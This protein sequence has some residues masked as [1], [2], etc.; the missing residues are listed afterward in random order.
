[1]P[2]VARPDLNHNIIWQSDR[3]ISAAITLRLYCRSGG[4]AWQHD[5]N[6]SQIA[7]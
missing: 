4:P 5:P 2:R 3:Y 1:M 7:V 6:S